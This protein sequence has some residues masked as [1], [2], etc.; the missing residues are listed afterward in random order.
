M[1][2]K[3]TPPDRELLVE[4]AIQDIAVGGTTIPGVEPDYIALWAVN[5]AGQV[6]IL[7][8]A[9]GYIFNNCCN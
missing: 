8:L 2:S 6:M 1:H 4:K 9:F 7:P 3:I 5:F